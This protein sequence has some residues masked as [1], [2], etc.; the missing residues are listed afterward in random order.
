MLCIS[1]KRTLE[2]AGIEFLD[3]NGLRLKK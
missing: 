1:I 2:E 3:D